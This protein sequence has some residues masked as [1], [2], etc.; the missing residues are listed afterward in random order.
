MRE[1]DGAVR[2]W[3]RLLREVCANGSLVCIAE[4]ERHD[5]ISGIAEAVE[6]FL[7]PAHYEAAVQALRDTRETHVEDPRAYLD[8]FQRLEDVERLCAARLERIRAR[9]ESDGD[10]S[11]YGLVNAITATARDVTDWRDRLD[12]EDLAGRI[13]WL[14]RP[15]PSRS[16]G[17]V[18]ARA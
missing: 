18:L 6:S 3:P 1:G 9:F 8:E 17:G 11:L 14:R 5:G 15:I 7:T 16:G 2:A 12:L 4:L 13:A 10:S